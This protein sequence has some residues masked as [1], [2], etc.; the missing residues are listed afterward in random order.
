[1]SLNRATEWTIQLINRFDQN[2]DYSSESGAIF[3]SDNFEISSLKISYEFTNMWDIYV[4]LTTKPGCR[5][6]TKALIQE[7][8]ISSSDGRIYDYSDDAF[9]SGFRRCGA[10]A[11]AGIGPNKDLVIESF[12]AAFIN[13]KKQQYDLSESEY[14]SWAD[15]NIRI[16][17]FIKECEKSFDEGFHAMQKN[18][19]I[20]S[21]PVKLLNEAEA[22][23][24]KEF[25]SAKGYC[26]KAL[27]LIAELKNPL[28]SSL[29]KRANKIL[30]KA[31]ECYKKIN[32]YPWEFDQSYFINIYERDAAYAFA[33]KSIKFATMDHPKQYVQ[34]IIVN[35]K[36]A[37]KVEFFKSEKTKP[38]HHQEI[39]DFNISYTSK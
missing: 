27:I 22:C 35:K 14:E 23:I 11:A 36:L 33:K 29:R 37:S 6:K 31:L 19:L 18:L 24:P 32:C 4:T 1:M 3:T 28:A 25:R 8:G 30:I 21:D 38:K 26:D 10:L 9:E 5:E 7:C 39:D 2:N 16:E 13:Q 15:R 34:E 20:Q 12:K 17:D